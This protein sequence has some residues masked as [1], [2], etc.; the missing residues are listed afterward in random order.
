MVDHK[1]GDA[2]MLREHTKKLIDSCQV[3]K[4]RAIHQV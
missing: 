4:I 2:E 3:K 1:S